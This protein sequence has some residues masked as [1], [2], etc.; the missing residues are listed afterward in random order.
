MLRISAILRLSLAHWLSI[1]LIAVF[2]QSRLIS[3]G[4]AYKEVSAGMGTL[5]LTH[6]KCRFGKLGGFGVPA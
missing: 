6:E 1:P 3:M 4:T 2:G 5:W